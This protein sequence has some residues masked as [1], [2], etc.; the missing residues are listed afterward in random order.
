MFARSKILPDRISQPRAETIAALLNVYTSE[1]VKRSLGELHT[2][3]IK[4]CDSQVVLH[5]I[6][7]EEKPLKQW[8]RDRVIEIRRFTSPTDWYP[9][10]K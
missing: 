8:V 9:Q 2:S 5:W 1:V 10:S 6:E 4:L 3:S 7:N